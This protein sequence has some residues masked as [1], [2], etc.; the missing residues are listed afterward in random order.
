M[1][2]SSKRVIKASEVEVLSHGFAP[3]RHAATEIAATSEFDDWRKSVEEEIEQLRRGAQEEAEAI[4]KN[5]EEQAA[6]ILAEAHQA[7]AALREEQ[8]QLGF[9]EGFQKGKE[10]GYEQGLREGRQVAEENVRQEWTSLL[11]QL[12][13]TV[14]AAAAVRDLALE[15]AEEDI[16]KLSLAVAEK[17]IRRTISDDI[18]CTVGIVKEAL[19][20][21][22][23]G[24]E[25]IVRVSPNLLE[26][27]EANRDLLSSVKGIEK[28][29]FVADSN[30]E[31][32]GCLI[33]TDFGRIDGRLD[34]RIA[35][36]TSALMEVLEDGQD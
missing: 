14:S 10:T 28:I 24:T 22:N 2:L 23:G 12:A 11:Q 13:D 36:V 26:I 3:F 19:Q 6:A 20:R 34:T 29:E 32:G 1:K 9:E 30:V 25:V 18:T 27:M 17:I 16:L 21:V 33:E 35:A 7:A 5:A 8:A 15:R 31:P 4:R